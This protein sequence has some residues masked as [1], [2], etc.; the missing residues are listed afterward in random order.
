MALPWHPYEGERVALAEDPE[1]VG[2]VIQENIDGTV[3]VRL[4]GGDYTELEPKDLIPEPQG[5]E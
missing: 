5:G 1:D 2:E 3:T 4:D